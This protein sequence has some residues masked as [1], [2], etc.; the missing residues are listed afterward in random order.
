MTPAVTSLRAQSGGPS[1]SA[2]LDTDRPTIYQGEL[3]SLTLSIQSSGVRLGQSFNL[4]SWPPEAQMQK[5][6]EFRELP[7]ARQQSGNAIYE[8]RRFRCDARAVSS[9]PVQVAPILHVGIVTRVNTFFGPQWTEADQAVAVQPL[10]LVFA[11]LPAQGRPASFSGAV[12]QLSFDASIEPSDVAVGDIVRLKMRIWGKGYLENLSPLHA[13]PGRRFKVYDSQPVPSTNET[14]KAFEQI[15]IPQSTNATAIPDVSFSYFD[16]QANGG[17]Y[18]TIVRGP[19]PLTFHAAQKVEFERFRPGPSPVIEAEKPAQ[20]RLPLRALQGLSEPQARLAE[21]A[22]QAYA[23]GYFEGAIQ[24]FEKIRSEAPA[25]PELCVNL[26]HAYAGAARYGPAMLNYLRALDL[27]PRDGDLRRSIALLR[28]RSGAILPAESGLR[29]LA[30]LLTPRQW[31]WA[32]LASLAAAVLAGLSMLLRLRLRSVSR[33]AFGLGVAA[34]VLCACCAAVTS[35]TRRSQ[36]VV[37]RQETA[38]FAP[39]TGAASSFALPAGSVV[40]VAGVSGLW[41]KVSADDNRGWVPAAS[42]SY[43]SRPSQF[44]PSRVK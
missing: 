35:S 33:A 30:S 13:A 20:H 38:R 12:G 25:S 7:I 2:R 19:F 23:E 6:T 18:R 31:R 32:A 21:Q 44:E 24:G 28:E 14:E 3:F 4:Q 22:A 36:A 27:C 15:L 41:L 17:E 16:P 11:P 8:I 29:Q 39:G 34:L 10:S 1:L 9:G 40:R 5:V 37:L 42:I 43:V 26:G